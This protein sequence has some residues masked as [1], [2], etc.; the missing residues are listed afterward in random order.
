[1]GILLLFLTGKDGLS[2]G[3]AWMKVRPVEWLLLCFFPFGLILGLVL[4]WWREA[5]GAAVAA[6]S[7]TAF[8][9]SCLRLTGRPPGGPWFLIFAA[10][11]VL[12]FASWFAHR[13]RGKSLQA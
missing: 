1:M 9:V 10:P 8:Y 2:S 7:V 11:A 5:L 3:N 4:A 13:R 12:F 6:L